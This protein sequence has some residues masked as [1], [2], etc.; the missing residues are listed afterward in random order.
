MGTG[1]GLIPD[2]PVKHGDDR[3]GHD[4]VANELARIAL[5]VDLPANIALYGR[6]GA[7]K[8]S[9]AN[10]LEAIVEA[11]DNASWV[12]Y[13]AFKWSGEAFHRHFLKQ[14]AD[15]LG[16]SFDPDDVYGAK[17][18]NVLDFSLKDVGRTLAS[19]LA[20]V[21]AMAVLLA[22]MFLVGQLVADRWQSELVQRVAG[23][24][25][26]P[27]TLLG[28]GFLIV[29]TLLASSI[30]TLKVTRTVSA[31]SSGEQFEQEFEKL[32]GP[33][34]K[35]NRRVV[36]FIDELDRCAAAD[37]VETLDAIRTFL[38]VPGCVCIVA[39][40]KQALETALSV[41]VA[42]E[43]PQDTTNPYYST[44]GAY[45]DKVFAYQVSLPPP[46]NRRLTSL[47]SELV[48]SSGGIWDDVE[49]PDRIVSVLVPTHVTSPRRVKALLNAYAVA[50]RL[51][52]RKVAG[53]VVEGP[54]ASREVE[55]AK[56]VCLQIEFPLFSREL[57]TDHLLPAV[58]LD[59][60]K[61]R[62]TNTQLRRERTARRFL[63]ADLAVDVDIS[64]PRAGTGDDTT[65]ATA[66]D[67]TDA[68]T[69]DA[70]DS[71]EEER[72]PESDDVRLV[73]QLVA[74]LRKTR[75]IDDPR[76]DLIHLEAMGATHGLDPKFARELQDLAVDLSD[77]LVTHVEGLSED[78]R[79]RAVLM[80]ADSLRDAVGLDVD[81][82][83]SSIL[84]LLGLWRADA[85][86]PIADRVTD[87]VAS[88]LNRVDITGDDRAGAL[89]LGIAS[90]RSA[91]K[92]LLDEAL[93][94]YDA[95]ATPQLGRLVVEHLDPLMGTGHEKQ[96]AYALA[97]RL[98]DPTT[99]EHAAE[100]LVSLSAERASRIARLAADEIH[101][102]LAGD[103]PD[104][105]ETGGDEEAARRATAYGET[106]AALEADEDTLRAL[107]LPLLRL[108][109]EAAR[110]AVEPVLPRLGRTDDARFAELLLSQTTPRL[111][112]TAWIE[113]VDWTAGLDLDQRVR[114]LI[115][116]LWARTTKADPSRRA[117]AENRE[118]LAKAVREAGID[119]RGPDNVPAALTDIDPPSDEDEAKSI[120]RRVDAARELV[121][122]GLLGAEATAE[123]LR[124][125]VLAWVR[126]APA[127]NNPQHLTALRERL[128]T[129]T[130]HMLPVVEFV[131]GAAAGTA[132][133]VT[134]LTDDFG[135]DADVRD[136]LIAHALAPVEGSVVTDE[137]TP[138]RVSDALEAQG[139]RAHELVAD[140]IRLGRPTATQI[141][142]ALDGHDLTRGGRIGAVA[143]ALGQWSNGADP[144]DVAAL[145][146]WVASDSDLS[147]WLYQVHDLE[148]MDG[149][150]LADRLVE[151]W[152][153][154]GNNQDRRR[155]L[156]VWFWA[157]TALE[158]QRKRLID[159]VFLD[160][161]KTAKNNKTAAS[162]AAAFAP[163][164]A[165]PPYGTLTKLRDAVKPLAA[166]AGRDA[167]RIA[168][169][170]AGVL[171]PKERPKKRRGFGGRK[172]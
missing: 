160:Y 22:A 67:E 107:V 125:T 81:N 40:D 27:V 43:T 92:R 59:L 98:T 51:M 38:D 63:D 126:S 46:L 49:D 156:D 23:S 145:V 8:S 132:E 149:N 50:Y 120:A 106:V 154:V 73:D 30:D 93:G 20:F 128:R 137:V 65:P 85:L 146:G 136:R 31:P 57:A 54:P 164:V 123:A 99:A 72:A 117:N 168:Y 101:D 105:D 3:L 89:V 14:A 80:L 77:Q 162:W 9:I 4:E 158:G 53:G 26:A 157:Q 18:T 118:A 24:V 19:S 84:R 34:T 111:R 140:W 86:G 133:I 75:H 119:L 159:V 48:R 171:E 170:N 74:Y 82:L 87:R 161:L 15:Q 66:E 134:A 47:A 45:L 25:L 36:V 155:V 58:M 70:A 32:I 110:T 152:G 150:A 96:A 167:V 94:D 104:D 129:Q 95:L 163:L 165:Q 108:D 91:R 127:A 17:S 88:E 138:E 12:R 148:H 112:Q 7:G 44:G 121:D 166:S 144:E 102:R 5:S 6:W 61:E 115:R 2:R 16:E 109:T 116:T 21:A 141:T 151:A 35:G 113:A 52:E 153:A 39:A 78:E 83:L 131:C 124:P 33:A 147:D 29:K 139:P 142:S 100:C 42:Q 114:T 97:A 130:P 122:V 37:V 56:L 76:P 13:D 135:G 55:L 71:P 172:R 11:D 143:D 90:S 1:L 68:D 64:R 28:A 69:V 62:T 169:E 41:A 79:A 103:E 10:A 60:A